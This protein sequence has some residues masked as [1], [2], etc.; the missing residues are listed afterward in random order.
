MA[1]KVE[2]LEML[3]RASLV[4][5]GLRSQDGIVYIQVPHDEIRRKA[6]DI[7]SH[8]LLVEFGEEP[9]SHKDT[10]YVEATAAPSGATDGAH[11]MKPKEFQIIMDRLDQLETLISDR[12]LERPPPQPIEPVILT[13]FRQR[14]Q[15]SK[16]LSLKNQ[17]RREA[18]KK[19]KENLD[20]K[21]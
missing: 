12:I 7:S 6:E 15:E 5:L 1:A 11:A 9:Y 14:C 8:G 2:I 3:D 21:K 20:A 10:L 19:A 13:S 17:E 16:A 18:R 4:L